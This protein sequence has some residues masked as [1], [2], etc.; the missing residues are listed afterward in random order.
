MCWQERS[1]EK[2]L[3]PCSYT[4]FLPCPIT[5]LSLFCSSPVWGCLQQKADKDMR[6]QGKGNFLQASQSPPDKPHGGVFT[7]QPQSGKDRGTR[8]SFSSCFLG[9]L[10]HLCLPASSCHHTQS[11]WVAFYLLA[12]L[13]ELSIV[14]NRKWQKTVDC[15]IHSFTLLL[16][17]FCV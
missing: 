12:L 9:L 11:H 1:W 17:K 14:L 7:E 4:R 16:N 10:P 2:F 8:E 13:H 15:T 5:V 6:Q 3:P